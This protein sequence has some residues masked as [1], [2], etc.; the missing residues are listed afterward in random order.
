MRA[1]YLLLLALVPL[2]HAGAPDRFTPTHRIM[3]IGIDRDD[4]SEDL[5]QTRTD[6]MIQSQTFSIMRE[7]LAVPGAKRITGN[8]KLQ[9]LF[10]SAAASSGMPVSI[11]EA[12]AYLESW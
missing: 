6:L 5:V 4:M 2:G 3:G 1:A 9:S 7:A 12:I 8:A 11:L 10:K